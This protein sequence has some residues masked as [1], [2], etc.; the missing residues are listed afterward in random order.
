LHG[1]TSRYANQDANQEPVRK[2]GP[3]FVKQWGSPSLRANDIFEMT[4]VHCGQLALDLARYS[5]M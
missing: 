5:A 2:S 1:A 4:M 3:R